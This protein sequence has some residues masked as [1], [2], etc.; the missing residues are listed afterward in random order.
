MPFS[1]ASP[2]SVIA[3]APQI[4]FLELAEAGNV[5]HAGVGDVRPSNRERLQ[6]SEFSDRLD[7]G[8]AHADR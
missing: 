8:V 7:S 2:R 5:L 6:S 3:V 4:E 1:S